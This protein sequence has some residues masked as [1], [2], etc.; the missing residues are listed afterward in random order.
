MDRENKLP[1]EGMV[2]VRYHSF[3][4]WHNGGSYQYFENDRD[5]KYRQ[6]VLD[7]NQYDLYTKSEKTYRL[8]DIKDYYLP[9]AVKYLGKGEIG[10]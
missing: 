4:P 10:W 3:Y 5:L 8:E 7:F 9:I 2:M 6:W 1:E